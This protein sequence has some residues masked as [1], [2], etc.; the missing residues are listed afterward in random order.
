[1]TG[2]RNC[3]YF[4]NL[5]LLSV[6]LPIPAHGENYHRDK[7]DNG[8]DNYHYAQRK[9]PFFLFLC[10]VLVLWNFLLQRI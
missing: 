7:T 5:S 1:M 8:E 9:R 6:R 3:S 10:R 4:S 2:D